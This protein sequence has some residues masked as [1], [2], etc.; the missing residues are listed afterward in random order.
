MTGS[1][2]L[3]SRSRS[4]ADNSNM[5]TDKQPRRFSRCAYLQAC[6]L[7]EELQCFGLK[8]DCVLYLES[9]GQE[10]DQRQFD[11]CMDE[12]INTTRAKFDQRQTT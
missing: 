2:G 8:A 10:Y 7:A 9:N 12:L 5:S 4:P 6:Y 3:P 1:V 11:A